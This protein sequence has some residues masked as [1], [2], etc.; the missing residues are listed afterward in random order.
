MTCF[1]AMGVCTVDD[2]LTRIAPQLFMAFNNLCKWR[3]V[4]RHFSTS[5]LGALW[6]SAPP[7]TDDPG[8][9]FSLA[10]QQLGRHSRQGEFSTGV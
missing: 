10:G 9:A 7:L 4:T 2:Q 8:S 3:E 5:L 1:W 6:F